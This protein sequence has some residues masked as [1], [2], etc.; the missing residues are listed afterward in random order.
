MKTEIR[1]GRHQGIASTDIP[2]GIFEEFYGESEDSAV[3]P[4]RSAGFRGQEE[5]E[6]GISRTPMRDQ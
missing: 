1:R 6:A 2:R 4:R 5:P 3:A